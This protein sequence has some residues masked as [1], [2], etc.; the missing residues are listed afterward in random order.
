MGMC[1]QISAFF[2]LLVH[3]TT[4]AICQ[5]NHIFL[6]GGRG[7]LSVVSYLFRHLSVVTQLSPSKSSFIAEQLETR[8]LL[9]C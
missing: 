8:I 3:L 6:A 4:N 7:D 1:V 9:H 2:Q 5:L